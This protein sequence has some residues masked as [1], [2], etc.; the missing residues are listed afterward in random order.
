MTSGQSVYWTARPNELTLI[1]AHGERMI[2]PRCDYAGAIGSLGAAYAEGR[3]AEVAGICI[4]PRR[5]IHLL[6]DLVEVVR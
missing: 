2:V 5:V 6:G 1:L 3:S 4:E